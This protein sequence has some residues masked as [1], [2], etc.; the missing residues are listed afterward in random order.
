MDYQ[1]F[2]DQFK[3]PC[4]II[5]VNK[6]DR[7]VRIVCANQ[8]FKDVSPT[9]KEYRD[10]M[11]Y[12][13]HMPRN[14]K[15][16]DF[17]YRAAILEEAGHVYAEYPT[18]WLDQMAIPM[19]SPDESLGL[20]QFSFV[21][22][23]SAEQRRMSTLSV[24][25]MKFAIRTGITLAS[26]EN[27]REGVQSVLEGALAISGAHHSRIFLMD[28]A[29]QTFQIYCDASDEYCLHK[30]TDFSYALLDSWARCVGDRI[31][32]LVT[33]SQDMDAIEKILPEWAGILRDCEVQSLVLLP[34]RRGQE[35]FGYVDFVD[36]DVRT[37]SE[38]TDV[39]E[40]L[41]VFLASEITNH[42]LMDRLEAMSTTDALTGLRNRAAMLQ[43]LESLDGTCFGVVNLD[44]N[45]L[46]TVNDT[47]GHEAGDRLLIQAAEALQ[48]VYYYDDIHRTGGDE[49]IVVM[50][51][52]A[53][54]TFDRKLKRFLET[55]EKN[56]EVSFAVGS[57]WSDGSVDLN[58]A[59]RLADDAMYADKKAFYRKNPQKRQR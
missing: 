42:Q 18:G 35:I 31:A 41:T 45:G 27:F 33:G 32:Y 4:A 34:L 30:H 25:V 57:Y 7:G 50:P 26:A 59:F 23:E 53:R 55:M 8:S 9:D 47:Q 39:A 56:D 51:G 2:V 5:S 20:C 19:A 36:F 13:E 10:G 44:V 15:F 54:E 40:L 22:T 1:S 48:K 37:A 52:I 38:V 46:K 6:L 12:F 16:E 58:T 14:P 3:R 21:L 29:R 11:Y 24:N 49:F 28:H 17:C 43:R